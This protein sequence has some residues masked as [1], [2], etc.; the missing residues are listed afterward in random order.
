MLAHSLPGA[1][2]TLGE[3]M[4]KNKK[5]YEK[6]WIPQHDVHSS[7]RL[8]T[9]LSAPTATS[10]QSIS[11]LAQRSWVYFRSAACTLE[12][13][14]SENK[15][16]GEEKEE[17][18]NAFAY[19]ASA[20]DALASAIRRQQYEYIPNVVFTLVAAR[21]ATWLGDMDERGEVEEKSKKRSPKHE[22]L[23]V[24]PVNAPNRDAL[25]KKSTCDDA[26]WIWYASGV[27]RMQIS[28]S[29]PSTR[30]G[31]KEV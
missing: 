9:F 26:T 30:T 13:T 20:S 18:H 2:D 29:R 14:S 16:G 27:P 4:V 19:L 8:A 11:T 31:G 17:S 5:L 3:C 24:R 6:I 25:L 1:A 28:A 15:R 22:F 10:L 23:E 12:Q 21:W 7:T